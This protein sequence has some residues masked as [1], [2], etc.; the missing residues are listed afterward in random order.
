MRLI[1]VATIHLL[2]GAAN[3]VIIIIGA[4]VDVRVVAT[5]AATKLS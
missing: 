2:L 1:C 4:R 3:V 5:A